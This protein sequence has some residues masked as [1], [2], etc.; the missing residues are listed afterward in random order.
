MRM[1]RENLYQPFEIAYDEVDECPKEGHQH[2]FFELVYIVDG[3]GKQCINKNKFDYHQGHLFLIT[4]QDCHSFEVENTTRFFF[5]RFSNRYLRSAPA[6]SEWVRRMEYILNNASHQPGCLLCNEG[7]KPLV[8]TM[9]E[10]MVREHVNRAPYHLEVVNQLVNTLITIVARNIAMRLPA[11]IENNK[12]E[13]IMNIIRYIQE[14]IY[15]PEKLRAETIGDLF[16]FS[17]GYLSRYFRKHTGESMQQYIV[18]YKLRLVET[19][20][21][22]SDM[23]INEIATEL[24]FTDESHLNR[25]FKRHKRISPSD[26]R[27]K[28]FATTSPS[29]QKSAG[30]TSR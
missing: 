16:G 27:K 19:R 17:K 4:P 10:S 18:E 9:V 2:N 15:E 8:R 20:L 13:E 12:G 28:M 25:L 30:A 23:R 3:T 5:V 29:P 26:Y 21:G 11:G 22:H 7:D 14:N 6:E 24:G 1:Q